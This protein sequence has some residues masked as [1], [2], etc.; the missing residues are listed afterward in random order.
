VRLVFI[1]GAGCT[2]DVFEFQRAAFPDAVYYRLPGHERPGEPSS[3]GE[4]ADAVLADLD[5]EVILAGH[6]MGGAVAL[7]CAL[8]GDPRVRALALLSSGARLRVGAAIFEGIQADFAAAAREIPHYFFADPT[9]ERLARATRMMERVGAEQ[10]LRDF[11]ACDAFDAIARLPDV[12]VPLLALT[13]ERDVMTPPKFALALADRVPG[14]QAR[15]LE[16][17]GHLAIAERPAETNAA[18]LAFVE[19]VHS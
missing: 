15:I 7:E 18:L 9:P 5:G 4:F 17:A 10:T 1:H 3:I 2:A 6:S 11:R 12:G 19:Q 13:G 16:G 8:R 14:A